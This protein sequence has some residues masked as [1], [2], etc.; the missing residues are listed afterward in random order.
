SSPSQT[1]LY[2]RQLN[3]DRAQPLAGTVGAALPFWSPDGREIGFFAR[4]SLRKID[5]SGGPV[6][7][8]ATAPL[9]R[10]A[11]WSPA[12][13]IVFGPATS[14]GLFKVSE[15]GGPV[16]PATQLGPT[17]SIHR[18]PSFLPDGRHF[19]YQAL[20]YGGSA[21]P[22]GMIFVGSIDDSSRVAVAPADSQAV[23]AP[24][25]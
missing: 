16:T 24:S 12:G 18:F 4:A 5:A 10:G 3:G 14:S 13:V 11:A 25:G 23:F 19:F 21:V 15:D 9:A 20:T 7:T 6:T 2:V 22:R 8:V 17:E 1:M